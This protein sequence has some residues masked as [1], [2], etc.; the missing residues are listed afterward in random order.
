MDHIRNFSIIAHIDHGKSTLVRCLTGL[1][2][3]DSGS[4]TLAGR[5]MT[6]VP[7]TELARTLAVVPGSAR[8]PFSMTVQE[9]V[10]LGR[11]ELT[12]VID[13]PEADEP[14]IFDP[15]RLTD[16]IEPSDDK[17]LAIRPKAYS[18]SIERRTRGA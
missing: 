4:V 8:L 17:I 13:D 11:L 15:M 14:L 2:Q 16:G 1:L 5:P 18:V 6:S 3:P 10:T 9:V 12:E 7:R